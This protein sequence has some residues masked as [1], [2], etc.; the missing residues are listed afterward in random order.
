KIDLQSVMPGSVLPAGRTDTAAFRRLAV[1]QRVFP[2][3]SPTGSSRG[4]SMY[5]SAFQASFTSLVWVSSA[6]LRGRISS[7]AGR[8][9]S[10]RRR[11]AT[12]CALVINLL[13]N[14][15]WLAERKA[16]SS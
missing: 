16:V 12:L 5:Q 8:P 4:R 11:G 14:L 1:L 15:D 9:E 10:G 7:T 3:F 6:T 2:F 13:L